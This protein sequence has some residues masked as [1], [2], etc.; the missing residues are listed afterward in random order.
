MKDIETI[1]VYNKVDLVAKHS[2]PRDVMPVSAKTNLGIENLKTAIMNRLGFER[3]FGSSF[4]AR[5]RHVSA[6]KRALNAIERGALELEHH[7]AWELIAEELKEC[8]RCL[9]EITGEFSTDDLLG[10]IFGSFC[11]GK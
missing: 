3:G 9:S 1:T 5:M 4:T 7:S 10:E 11:I 2:F 8:Q 6:L